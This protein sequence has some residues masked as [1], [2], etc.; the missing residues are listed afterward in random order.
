VNNATDA[1]ANTIESLIFV[2]WANMLNLR[3]EA[4]PE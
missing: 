4:I 1:S 2:R 3:L